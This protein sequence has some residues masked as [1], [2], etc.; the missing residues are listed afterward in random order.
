MASNKRKII[1]DPVFGFINIPN[2]FIYDLIEHPYFQRLNRIRQLGLAF[3]VYPG[4]QHTRFQHSLGA[5]H[6]TTEAIEQLRGKGHT[7]TTDEANGV[8]AAIL[9]HDIGH[10]PFSHVLEHTLFSGITHEE[11]SIRLMEA[12]NKEIGG[13]LTM[14]LEIF[15]DRYP[16]KFLHQ[17]ISSQLDMDRLDYLRRDCFY[18]GVV[19]GEIGSARIIKMLDVH[20]DR[21][22]VERK[23]V[24]SIENFL[25]ARRFMYWQ[26]YLHKTSIGAE[27]LLIRILRRA[28]QLCMQGK[29]VFATP[30]LHYFLEAER[31]AQ[32]FETD[33]M[34]LHHFTN[35]DDNDLLSAIKVWQ[36]H[37]DQILAMLS[38]C[39]LNRKLMKVITLEQPMTA[40][41]KDN[42]RKH[43][44]N[45]LGITTDEAELFFAERIVRQGTY[46]TDNS[47]I[48]ILTSD[49]NIKEL[50]QVGDSM[51]PTI[52]NHKTIRVF[53]CYIPSEGLPLPQQH[54][55][56]HTTDPTTNN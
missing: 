28:K 30:A 41:E 21:L 3:Y 37:P 48:G 53:L 27:E 2:E 44:A 39:L 10:G 32:S 29:E 8:M 5:L 11:I 36:S 40:H 38:R 54:N 55:T 26:V 12:I 47:G 25:I 23:G 43:Y 7:I 17:L 50:S 52:L 18:T 45:T 34:V 46:D 16:R 14:A 24:Y 6:L 20:H 35:L 13:K 49:G 31:N 1:N 22:V 19:E 15:R 42:I 56:Q 4:A 33:I 9:L 51:N